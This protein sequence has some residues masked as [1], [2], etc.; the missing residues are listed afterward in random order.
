MTYAYD[1]ERLR[2]ACEEADHA[3]DTFEQHEI[4][5]NLALKIANL[6]TDLQNFIYETE[7]DACDTRG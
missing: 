7:N 3:A 4:P 5:Y 1:L 2:A 6:R